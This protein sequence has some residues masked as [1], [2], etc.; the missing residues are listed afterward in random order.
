[1]SERLARLLECEAKRL[2]AAVGIPT[3]QGRV[4]NSPDEA[5]TIAAELGRAV[6][7]KAQIRVGKRGKAGAI[8]F[9]DDADTA[10]AAT[11]AHINVDDDALFRHPELGI[12]AG[13]IAA[14][15]DAGATVLDHLDEIG[16]AVAAT[17][18]ARGI[19]Q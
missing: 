6:A 15:R 3:P 5:R 2:L 16:P 19:R 11:D 4:A 7:V 17:L 12:A 13:K 10:A 9:A 14:L 18:A 1:M 8:Q